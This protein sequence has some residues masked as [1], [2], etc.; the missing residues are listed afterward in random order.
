[1][2][3]QNHPAYRITSSG[4]NS[5]G[6]HY[7]HRDYGSSV[8]NHNNYHYSNCT[9]YDNGRGRSIYTAPNGRCYVS[10]DNVRPGTS[11]QAGRGDSSAHPSTSVSRNA[12]PYRRS[13]PRDGRSDG[14]VSTPNDS[15]GLWLPSME[16]APSNTN[17]PPT[18]RDEDR[19]EEGYRQAGN[20]RNSYD[21]PGYR[22][23]DNAV[24][25][26][27]DDVPD[28]DE[29]GTAYGHDDGYYDGGYDT[30]GHDAGSY[31][32]DGYGDDGFCDDGF[33]DDGGY[34]DDGYYD[35]GGYDDDYICDY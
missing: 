3:Y 4:V 13:S 29:G 22:G 34:D 12:S 5:Q 14:Q 19:V 23:F 15:L 11:D 8:P 1:M 21:A 33:C 18:S 16:R 24:D 2:P 25:Y 17:Y 27:R 30:C 28:D 35:D 26:G 6:N 32:A 20:V 9:Y 31:D 7:C 10:A